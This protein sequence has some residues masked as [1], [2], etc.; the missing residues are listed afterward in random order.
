MGYDFFENIQRAMEPILRQEKEMKRLMG[1]I[2]R[3]HE[4]MA[5]LAN[6]L[7]LAESAVRQAESATRQYEE[8]IAHLA[9]PLGLAESALGGKMFKAVEDVVRLEEKIARSANPLGLVGDLQR[10]LEPSPL[11]R[12]VADVAKQ[13][14]QREEMI[15][16]S[17]NPVADL[18]CKL[19]PSLP[20]QDA[21][22]RLAKQPNLS[23]FDFSKAAQST[24]IT[25]PSVKQPNPLRSFILRQRD[26]EDTETD[27]FVS[28]AKLET[29]DD[30]RLDIITRL[31]Q[32]NPQLVVPYIGAWGALSGSNADR[33]RH[34]L[35]SLRDL[36]NHLL[37]QLA[38]DDLVVAWIQITNQMDL[39]DD[40]GKPTR[41]GK[42]IYLYR[43]FN[44]YRLNQ[45]LM[46]HIQELLKHI[47][48][49][50]RLHEL[51]IGLTH[52]RLRTTLVTTDSLLMH[53]LRTV[54][55]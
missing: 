16:K 1:P 28:E 15:A 53:I 12:A 31:E 54:H 11:N 17:L 48:S 49:L 32:V 21:I 51:K 8:K 30:I 26:E 50:N 47:N 14:R 4:E 43:E 13:L 44:N 7:D 40:K 3:Q 24:L 6:P 18:R 19:E 29:S 25:W 9:N 36:W 45:F 10:K 42:M 2:L 35:T 46:P 37:R 55:P 39:L 33:A 20:H 22:D 41:K 34:I 38:P 52:D 23:G 27:Q 5:R